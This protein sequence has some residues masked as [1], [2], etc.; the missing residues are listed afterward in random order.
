MAFTRGSA[1]GSKLA[2]FC[3]TA[4]SGPRTYILVQALSEANYRR[5]EPALQLDTL[6]LEHQLD[7]TLGRSGSG[8]GGDGMEMGVAL[9]G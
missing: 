6:G 3:N 9:L 2:D 5:S 7:S 4:S 8:Q 1:P